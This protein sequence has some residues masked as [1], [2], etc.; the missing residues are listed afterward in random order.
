MDAQLKNV[1]Q[2]CQEKKEKTLD[3]LLA[4][5]KKALDELEKTLKIDAVVTPVLCCGLFICAIAFSVSL[6]ID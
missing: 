4:E 2:R 1:K 3:Q 6:F 5:E